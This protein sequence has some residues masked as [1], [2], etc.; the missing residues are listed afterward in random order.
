MG[1]V[2][3]VRRQSSF[4]LHSKHCDKHAHFGLMS[5]NSSIFYSTNVL[6][7]L[8]GV[9]FCRNEFQSNHESGLSHRPETLMTIPGPLAADLCSGG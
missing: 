1:E 4:F 7:V 6:S 8:A 9:F 2:T 3:H 5:T